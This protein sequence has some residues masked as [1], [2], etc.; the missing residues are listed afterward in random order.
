MSSSKGVTTDFGV[1][2]GEKH[3]YTS[4]GG[5]QVTVNIGGFRWPNGISKL[6][7]RSLSADPAYLDDLTFPR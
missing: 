1:R 2:F 3:T 6:V 4:Q 7:V 5:D